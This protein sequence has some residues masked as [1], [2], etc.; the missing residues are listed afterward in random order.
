MDEAKLQKYRKKVENSNYIRLE[1]EIVEILADKEKTILDIG[2]AGIDLIGKLP[3]KE[4]CS[5]ALYGALNTDKIKGYEM[6]FFDFKPEK[7]IDIVTCFQVIEHVNEAKIFTQKLL[8]TGRTLVISLP[9]KWEKGRCK[10]HV[11]DPIDETKIYSWTSKKAQFT[12]YVRDE[13]Y[14][15]IMCIYGKL[16]FKQKLKLHFLNL[17]YL[18]N[19]KLKN[20]YSNVFEWFFSVKNDKLSGYKNLTILGVKMKLC[21]SNKYYDK[22]IDDMNKHVDKL[23]YKIKIMENYL[24]NFYKDAP[25]SFPVSLSENEKKMLCE[26]Y[27]KSKKCLE[28]GSGGSTFLA[29]MNSD[30]FVYSVESDKDWIDYLKT[31]KII[32]TNENIRLKLIHADIGKT[33]AWG[34]PAD[35]NDFEKFSNY[36][37]LIFEKFNPKDIDTIFIGGRFRVA[38][39]LSSILNCSYNIT[40]LIHDYTVREEYHIVEEFLDLIEQIDSLCVFKLKENIDKCRV[41]ELYEKYKLITR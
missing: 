22:K 14:W 16:T 34:Y 28:F 41:A 33:C 26:Y 37:N 8:D 40:I 24:S 36:S 9:Y 23:E 15:R 3:F 27:S 17:K 1:K 2:S 25:K 19:K 18:K 11:Q 38:C 21:R 35:K 10:S 4:R 13:K 30:C 29:L 7:K 31:Y 12:F 6:D 5:V 32:N 20:G 39:V